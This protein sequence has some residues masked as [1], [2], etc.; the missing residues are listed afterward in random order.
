ME[1]NYSRGKRFG[2]KFWKCETLDVLSVGFLF[3]CNPLSEL[4]LA[5]ASV[6]GPDNTPGRA[7]ER[8]RPVLSAFTRHQL[9]RAS[10]ES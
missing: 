7:P 1:E 6:T 10:S 4:L 3:W 9:A 5:R 8:V 2:D